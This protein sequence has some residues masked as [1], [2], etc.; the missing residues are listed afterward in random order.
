MEMP[1][2]VERGCGDAEAG[3]LYGWIPMSSHGIPIVN[4]LYDY[5]YPIPED[6]EIKDRGLTL[7]EYGGFWHVIDHVGQN[8]YPNF[9]DWW[10]EI[11]RFGFHQR[12]ESTLDFEKLDPAGSLWIVSHSRG[13]VRS[14]NDINWLLENAQYDDRTHYNGCPT[15]K[16]AFEWLLDV[17]PEG[18]CTGLLWQTLIKGEALDKR[19]VKRI[20]P[21]FE[22]YGFST[23]R[24]LEFEPAFLAAFPI[25]MMNWLVY[26]G[27]N[28]EED[29]TLKRLEKAPD[30][31]QPVL[32]EA[33]E[34]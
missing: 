2:M 17:E 21:S 3:G 7:F 11:C 4:F 20:M 18:F 34:A 23:D 25:R 24:K 8:N 6:L 19:E 30:W 16:H 15:E 5:P 29:T 32:I 13:L 33:Q 14:A 12:T 10:E 31:V 28:G 27:K 9:T 1:L 26:K 22:Y